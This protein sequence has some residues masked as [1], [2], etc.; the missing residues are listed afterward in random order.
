MFYNQPFAQPIRI[1]LEHVNG[2]LFNKTIN[3]ILEFY[4]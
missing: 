3:Q 4:F 2:T 1:N